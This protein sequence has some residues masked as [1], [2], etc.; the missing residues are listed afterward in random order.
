MFHSMV[1]SEGFQFYKT[2]YGILT[3][4]MNPQLCRMESSD[5]LRFRLYKVFHGPVQDAIIYLF[6]QTYTQHTDVYTHICNQEMLNYFTLTEMASLE[7]DRNI[8]NHNLLTQYKIVRTC[9]SPALVSPNSS[10]WTN[11]SKNSTSVESM[12]CWLVKTYE[13][14]A[15]TQ[16]T[17]TDEIFTYRVSIISKVLENIVQY[18]GKFDKSGRWRED[19]LRI[20]TQL[21]GILQGKPTTGTLQEIQADVIAELNMSYQQ[22]RP[23][24]IDPTLLCIEK[25]LNITKKSEDSSSET[26]QLVLVEDLLNSAWHVEGQNQSQQCHICHII[27]EPSSGR[28]NLATLLAR[29]WKIKNDRVK[30]IR[31]YQAVIFVSGIAIMANKNQCLYSTVFPLSCQTHGVEMVKKWVVKDQILMIIDDAEDL[32]I[33]QLEE[34]ISLTKASPAMDLFLM[35]DTSINDVPDLLRD[36]IHTTLQIRGYRPESIIAAAEYFMYHRKQDDNSCNK[37][38]TFLEQNMCRLFQL[39][40]LPVMLELVFETW[41]ENPDLFKDITT[42]TE[43]F[44][45]F[46]WWKT[47]RAIMNG[48]NDPN[49]KIFELLFA[50]GEVSLKCLN[51][52]IRL[53]GQYI[54]SLECKMEN[55]FLPSITH[56]I[57]L[58]IFKERYHH[59]LDPN[60]RQLSTI[61]LQHQEWLASWYMVRQVARGKPLFKLAP[62]ISNKKQ[63]VIFM[64]GHM[65]FMKKESREFIEPE[66]SKVMKAIVLHDSCS[67]ENLVFAMSVTAELRGNEELVTMLVGEMQFPDEFKLN[68]SEIQQVPLEALLRQVAPTRIVLNVDYF[69]PYSELSKA[70]SYI[71]RVGLYLWLDSP[72]MF[73]FG[74]KDTLDRVLKPFIKSKT[75]L[76]NIDMICGNVSTRLIRELISITAFRNLVYLQLV[77]KTENDLSTVLLV[78][79]YMKKMV[80]LE[81]KIDF[82][83]LKNELTSMTKCDVPLLDVYIQNVTDDQI[84]HL[85]DLLSWMHNSYSGIHLEKTSLSPEGVFYLLQELKKRQV[86]LNAGLE[87][88]W[89]FRRWYYPQ[90]SDTDANLVLSDEVS[91]GYLG[92]DDR[93]FYSNHCIESYK[94]VIALD[95]WNLTSYLEETESIVHFT[96]DTKNLT[97]VKKVDGSVSYDIKK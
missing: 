46:S 38:K 58:S 80:W 68:I 76:V 53:F 95:A 45:S 29:S 86:C 63:L 92:F 22:C 35:T 78:P 44:W 19:L 50:I 40:K 89:K 66:Q 82:D 88:R 90:L 55:L 9:C 94:F 20:M 51:E 79:K 37:L 15:S 43:L 1:Q 2:V 61:C 62:R 54:T 14:I 64:A 25:Q 13:E 69:K 12:L 5:L 71:A 48:T 6:N 31:K 93:S 47:Q 91:I 57:M 52:N 16:F 27:G 32:D 83:V 85:A 23:S 84:T 67:S 7:R 33:Q 65:L 36:I 39:L 97:F 34:I 74:S 8:R 72:K 59:G 49:S 21:Q 42:C 41:L 96:Y 18:G 60:Y 24:D 30:G 81:V 11:P 75:V 73:Q 28:T 77:V 17:L 10:E 3:L 70:L 26:L 4:Y 87:A 56:R